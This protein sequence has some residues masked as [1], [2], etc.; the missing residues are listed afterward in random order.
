V[1]DNQSISAK[2]GTLRGLHFQKPPRAQG[3]LI[4][5]LRGSIFDVAVD[6][7][8][9]SPSFGRHVAVTLDAISGTQLWV[10]A[11]FLHGFCTLEDDTE[12][13]YKV[14]EYYSPEHDAGVYWNDPD[15]EIDWPVILE[16]VVLSERDRRLPRLSELPEFFVYQTSFC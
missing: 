10:P 13:F 9:G 6:I 15:L 7:R 16:T 3:K 2:K 11:G 12:V 8:R 1:Q 4:R 5:V 14:S